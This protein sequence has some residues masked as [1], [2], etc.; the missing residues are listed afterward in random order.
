MT[1][2]QSIKGTAEFET[3]GVTQ[4]CGLQSDRNIRD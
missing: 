1:V 4:M 2:L 3:T